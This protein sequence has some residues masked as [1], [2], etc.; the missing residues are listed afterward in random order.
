V[1]AIAI[2]FDADFVPRKKLVDLVVGRTATLDSKV[3]FRMGRDSHDKVVVIGD[4]QILPDAEKYVN[5]SV[6]QYLGAAKW[7]RFETEKN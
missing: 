1:S 7:D 2:K 5:F 4:P 6:V 3:V